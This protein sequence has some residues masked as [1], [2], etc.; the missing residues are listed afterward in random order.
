MEESEIIN[1]EKEYSQEEIAKILVDAG[2][3]QIKEVKVDKRTDFHK[4]VDEQDKEII[5]KPDFE[6]DNVMYDVKEVE[7]FD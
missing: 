4:Y 2:I 7:S 6:N 1:E 5:E 3:K